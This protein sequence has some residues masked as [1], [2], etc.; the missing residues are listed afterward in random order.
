MRSENVATGYYWY[1][2]QR[3]RMWRYL[4]LFLFCAT[5]NPKQLL[6]AAHNDEHDN[7][8]TKPLPLIARRTN[9][10]KLM[11]LVQTK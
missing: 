8:E 9:A 5:L 7:T 2:Q 6:L 4:T 11:D 1:S 3:N 10:H